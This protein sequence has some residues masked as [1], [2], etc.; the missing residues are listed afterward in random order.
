MKKT[1]LILLFLLVSIVRLNA[2]RGNMG[3]GTSSPHPSALLHIESSDKGVMLPVV[4]LLSTKDI[5]TIANPKTGFVVYNQNISGT[6]DATV[7]KGIY[8]YNGQVWEKMLTRS[9][10]N[11]EISKVPFIKAVF[12]AGNTTTSPVF[13]AGSINNLTFNSLYRDS[14]AGA[15]GPVG[16]YTGY[17][18]KETGKYSITYNAGIMAANT[19]M[20]YIIFTILKNGVVINTY[21]VERQFQFGGIS[22]TVSAD[23]AISDII[24]FQIRGI[25]VNY[26][27]T[28]TNVSIS[29]IFK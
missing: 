8:A 25:N 2:Q 22:G 19:N 6:G 7:S 21:A 5:T 3:I 26:Q 15:Q 16:A 9:E 20:G 4:S 28:H 14:P 18:V 29:K 12:A 17:A 10:I 11:T 1:H 27:T 23:L 24:T 13:T